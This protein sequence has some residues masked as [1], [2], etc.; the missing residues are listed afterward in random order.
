MFIFF[1]LAI[2]CLLG[3]AVVIFYTVKL[4]VFIKYLKTSGQFEPDFQSNHK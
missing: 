1:K 4:Y 3:H 2:F